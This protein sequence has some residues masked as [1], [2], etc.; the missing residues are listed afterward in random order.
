MKRRSNKE[1]VTFLADWLRQKGGCANCMWTRQVMRE[2]G[3]TNGQI[4]LAV[5]SLK[6]KVQRHK[7]DSSFARTFDGWILT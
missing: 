6:V 5:L 4:R 1:A 3:F 7:D 2:A